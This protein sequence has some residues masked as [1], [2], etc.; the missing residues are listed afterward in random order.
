MVGFNRRSNTYGATPPLAFTRTGLMRLTRV[1][2][3]SFS[4]TVFNTAPA[5][6]NELKTTRVMRGTAGHYVVDPLAQWIECLDIRGPCIS[7]D[8]RATAVTDTSDNRAHCEDATVVRDPLVAPARLIDTHHCI[9]F[10]VPNVGEFM[11]RKV[12]GEY[13]SCGR[14]GYLMQ[15]DPPGWITMYAGDT[16]P[17][18]NP[19]I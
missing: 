19:T 5:I 13:S 14:T 15:G 9:R 1:G 17:S 12:H 8:T 16:V 3:Q 6:D 7:A 18:E 4:C 2:M 11:H 10:C